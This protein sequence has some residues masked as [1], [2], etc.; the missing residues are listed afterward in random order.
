MYA[1]QNCQLEKALFISPVLD[2]ERLILDMLE[3]ANVSEKELQV[4]GEVSTEFVETLSW[5][6]SYGGTDSFSR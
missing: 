5:K 1:L 2:M 4:K 3:K 6:Y